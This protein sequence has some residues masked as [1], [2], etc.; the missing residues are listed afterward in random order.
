MK[1]LE[2]MKAALNT[3]THLLAETENL[4]PVSI[5]TKAHATSIPQAPERMETGNVVDVIETQR[6]EEPPYSKPVSFQIGQHITYKVPIIK[7]PVDYTWAWR[8]GIVLESNQELE[9]VIVT[10][11]D[12]PEK[13]IGI[14]FVYVQIY[15]KNEFNE[16]MDAGEN[17]QEGCRSQHDHP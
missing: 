15:E 6:S 17:G 5:S 9:M 14:P 3:Q 16:I 11:S 1:I 10:P 4:K 7:T 12:A 13:W 2:Q 8:H